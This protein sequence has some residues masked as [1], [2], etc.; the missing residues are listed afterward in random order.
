MFSSPVRLVSIL[1]LVTVLPGCAAMQRRKAHD[2]ERQLM[3]AGFQMR[4]ADTPEKL[5]QIQAMPQRQIVPRQHGGLPV[6]VYA[7]ADYCKCLYV[8]TERVYRRYE[9]IALVKGLVD[10]R[11]ET[12]AM[13]EDAA[14]NLGAWGPW[15]P[16]WR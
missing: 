2:T 15:A 7:D 6:F 9:R 13:Q 11:R 14:M 16:W 12:A 4:L 5:D 1:L 3:A 8:G 10:E